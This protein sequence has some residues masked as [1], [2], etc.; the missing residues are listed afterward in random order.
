[1]H[2][3]AEILEG[4]WIPY[5]V[6]AGENFRI[7]RYSYIMPPAR[8][9]HVS[10]GNFCSIGENLRLIH[11]HHPVD[12]FSTFPFARRL[13][14]HGRDF[15]P[16]F[17]EVIDKGPVL[18]GHDV[19]I[20]HNCTVMGGVSIGTGAIIGTGS[21][22]TKDVEPYMIVGGV[23]A[24]PIRQRLSDKAVKKL[25]AS[26]WWDWPLEEISKR[27]EELCAMTD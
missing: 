3:D 14:M 6:H 7:G 26:Q 5:G 20:G 2:A 8:L 18:I 16:L 21:V 15:Q 13:A 23:P 24:K 19:W 4:A 9:H 10:I 25:L 12:Q 1:M 17:N 27:S 22:V 11:Y